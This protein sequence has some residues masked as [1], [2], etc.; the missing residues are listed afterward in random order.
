MYLKKS[1][2]KFEIMKNDHNQK[3]SRLVYFG[4]EIWKMVLRSTKN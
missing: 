2:D 3:V 4:R 1:K